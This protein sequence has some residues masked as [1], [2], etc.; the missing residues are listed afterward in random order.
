VVRSWRWAV[1]VAGAVALAAVPAIIGALPVKA[2]TVEPSQLAAAIVAS[3]AAPYQGYVETRGQL[4]IPDLPEVDTA[5]ALLGG[6]AKIRVWR[7]D[8]TAWRVDLLTTT[9][10][11]DTYGDGTGTWT[12][13]SNDRRVARTEQS[14]TAVRL[15]RPADVVPPELGRR[16]VAGAAPEELRPLG[17][18]RVAGRSVPGVRVVPAN[19]ATTV[20]HVDVWADPGSGVVLRVGVISRGADRPVFESQFLDVSLSPP[21]RSLVTFV[22]PRGA[23]NRRNPNT[24][25]LQQLQ[26]VTS[27]T[28]LPG[29]LA[30][31]TRAPGQTGGVATYGD[32]FGVVT[33]LAVP[34]FLLNEAVPANFALTDRPWG[35]QA[36][37]VETQL[38]NAMAMSSGGRGYV[39]SGAV[40]LQ[41][42]DRVAAVINETRPGQ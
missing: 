8:P 30:G 14:P 27:A 29:S 15:P 36:R 17:A 28:Q 23:R 1:V 39:L 19:P 6:P 41:E 34:S 7:A 32:G 42:L 4:G 40:T 21:D 35:G 22:R 16:I 26:A 10:E 5:T 11:T 2:T 3:T 25:L 12:W 18:T 24:D 31:L 9:G 13:D 33:V 20:D 37:V 38:V